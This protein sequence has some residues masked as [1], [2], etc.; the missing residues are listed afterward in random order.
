[1]ELG[2]KNIN[3]L[4]SKEFNDLFEVK[5][6]ERMT[7]GLSTINKKAFLTGLITK[8]ILRPDKYIEFAQ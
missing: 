7:K 8:N 2:K 4:T 6:K 1:M 3:D 5:M